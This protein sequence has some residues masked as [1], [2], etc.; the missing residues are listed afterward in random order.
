MYTMVTVTFHRLYV[1]N[2]MFDRFWRFLCTL[3]LKW[4]GEGVR[5]NLHTESASA[6]WNYCLVKTYR[7]SGDFFSLCVFCDRVSVCV[8]VQFCYSQGR[9]KG[10]VGVTW[11]TR[12]L[13][14]REGGASTRGRPGWPPTP[15][16]GSR[17][18]LLVKILSAYLFYRYSPV[19]RL[20]YFYTCFL[21]CFILLLSIFGSTLT[22]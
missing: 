13:E 19:S 2:N 4:V 15:S 10:R 11:W 8:S 9:P 12:I 16:P 7:N 14:S 20:F 22:A 6:L 1:F 21:F 17:F 18:Y 5:W 3:V